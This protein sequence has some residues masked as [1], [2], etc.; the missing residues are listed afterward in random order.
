MRRL[1]PSGLA[2]VLATALAL[3]FL[4]GSALAY[5]STSGAGNA[6]TLLTSISK[7]TITAATP[8]AGGTVALTWS[9]V[10]PPGAGTVAYYV[11]RD[12]G[13]PEGS[14]P[15]SGSPTAVTTCTDTGLAIGSHTY[16]VTAVWHSWT[17]KSSPSSA[18]ITIGPATHFTISAATTTPA[19]GAA[20]NLTITAKDAAESTVTTFTGS[21]SLVFSGASSSPGGNAPTVV[22]N[23]S[24][25][26]NFG[27]A[28]AITFTTGV[29]TVTSSKNGVM[30]IYKAGAASVVATEGSLTTTT[31]LA[32]TVSAGA[33]TKY[34]L[35]AETT[36]PTAGTADNLT[37]TA[38]DTYGNT[39]T[40]YTGSHNLIFSGASPS[41]GG[42]APTVADSA[43]VDT[44]FGA[45]TAIVFNAGLATAS[46]GANG[47]M[48]LYKSGAA[49]IKATEGT[50]TN[51][52][53]LALTVAAAPAVKLVLTSSSLTPVAAASFNLTTTAVDVYG[54][55]ATAYAGA[56]SIVFSGPTASPAGT[57][58]TVVN[59]AGAVINFGAATALTFTAGVAAVTSSK[60]GLTRLYKAGA[61]AITATDGSIS[62][63]TALE[64]TV[65]VGA[66]ARWALVSTVAS[67][68]T[69]SSPCLFTCTVTLLGNAGT[70]NASVAV[71][72]SAGNTVSELGSGHVAKVTATGGTILGTPLT[73]PTTGPAVSPTQFTYTAPLTGAFSNT[74]TVATSTGTAYTSATLTAS[75]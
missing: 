60:N 69:L 33:A 43:D 12:G 38:Q 61:A 70:V 32:L 35:A 30:K 16:T 37:I 2:G 24:T 46:G 29:A 23:A 52:T 25:A 48:L 13:A 39:A 47:S 15:S 74:I 22:N 59:S 8:A 26:I 20:D 75:R 63:P 53:A 44:A 45:A 5:F 57:L 28:T 36:T 71:T 54:N 73:I 34:A 68:G 56:K 21:H 31:P 67:A 17:A 19:V 9:A 6:S 42:N 27:S 66:A 55:T 62:T 7:P 58:P 40:S 65:G 4:G 18:T 11:S 3:V 1:A 51:A 10:S 50:I 41:P 49:A 72:D 64:L 14:C